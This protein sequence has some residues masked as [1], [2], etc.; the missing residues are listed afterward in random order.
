MA[1]QSVQLWFVGEENKIFKVEIWC[2]HG[3]TYIEEPLGVLYVHSE[4]GKA[5]VRKHER[6]TK[7][8]QRYLEGSSMVP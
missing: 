7:A 1:V 8:G 4:E 5:G 6:G 3:W 2:A